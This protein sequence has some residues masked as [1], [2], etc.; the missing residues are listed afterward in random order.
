MPVEEETSL[1]QRVKAGDVK[2]A[3]CSVVRVMVVVVVT[4][5]VMGDR[6][7][8]V[9]DDDDDDDSSYD[10]DNN[11]DTNTNS[12]T[13][14]PTCTQKK[15]CRTPASQARARPAALSASLL[16]GWGFGG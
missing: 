7:D 4:K 12:V 16:E 14:A 13:A 10:D 1:Q 3:A 11:K 2:G 9:H 6:D 5:I 8:D 15:K